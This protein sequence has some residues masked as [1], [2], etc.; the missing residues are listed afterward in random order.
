MKKEED[1]FY[2]TFNII[3]IIVTIKNENKLTN[4]RGLFLKKKK[5][6]VKVISQSKSCHRSSNSNSSR[7]SII[8]ETFEKKNIY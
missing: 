6:C 3:M 7:A 5:N 1:V 8:L 4:L 2:L